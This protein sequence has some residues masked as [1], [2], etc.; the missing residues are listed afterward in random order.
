MDYSKIVQEL[1]KSSLFDVYRLQ[2]A[3]NRLLENP[4]RIEEIRRQ[5][6][7]GQEI[8]YFDATENREIEARVVKLKQ[9]RVLV[10]HKRDQQRWNI[11]LYYVNLEGVDTEIKVSSGKVGLDKS[12]LKVGDR[13]GFR[14]QQNNDLYGEVIRLNPKT[15]TIRLE[16]STEWRV[17]YRLLYSVI[18]GEQ[19][20][21]R[22]LIEGEVLEGKGQG[23]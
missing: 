5:L 15:A 13:V 6:R 21:G 17:P 18:E 19:I 12:Q 1:Q 22:R 7:P 16:D 2:V 10:E 8:T 11:P 4:D 23:D 20:E 9:T 3:I 14:D